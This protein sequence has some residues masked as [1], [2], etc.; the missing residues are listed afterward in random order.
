M[1][2]AQFNDSYYPVFDGVVKAVDNHAIILNQKG[3]DS[4]VV[5]TGHPKSAPARDHLVYRCKYFKNPFNNTYIWPVPMLDFKLNKALKKEPIDLI[6]AHSPFMV[7]HL[8]LRIARKKRIPIIA[9]FHTKFYDDLLESTGSKIITKIAMGYIMRFYRHC[10]YVIT[11]SEHAK[12]TL[13]EY[14]YQG[15]IKVIP[16]GVDLT[17]PQNY[18]PALEALKKEYQIKENE[19]VFL[20]IGM[21]NF[22]KNIRLIYEALAIYKKQN[23]HFKLFMV[24]TGNHIKEIK[25]LGKTLKIDDNVI[26]TGLMSDQVK[27]TNLC[28]LADLFVFPSTYDTFSIVVR[29]AALGGTASVVVKD[30]GPAENIQHGING[31][32]CE[33]T[34]ESLAETIAEALKDKK[35]LKKVGAAAAKTLPMSW[36]VVI[37][38][39]SAFYEEVLKNK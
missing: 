34:A 33:N 38:E 26:Y 36:E 29:E 35:K 6:H 24:G 18:Q 10:D 13:Q 14:G 7:G 1:R 16:N 27:K 28:I 4:F 39:V 23:P 8:G 20:Y 15:N 30:S 9:T 17:V 5:A 22:K 21:Q 12:K 32:I 2:V 37:D 25:E 11:V 19:D 31:F 3:I